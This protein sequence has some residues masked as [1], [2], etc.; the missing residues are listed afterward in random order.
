MTSINLRQPAADPVVSPAGGTAVFDA[1]ANNPAALYVASL[2]SAHSR[3]TMRGALA[4][5]LAVIG[6][7]EPGGAVDT[8]AWHKLEY[9]H[10]A[11]IRAALIERYAPASVNKMLAAVRGVL[12]SA[13]HASLMSGDA[14]ER[15][16]AAA[17]VVK[18]ETLPAGRDIP[19]LELRALVEACK[20]DG[21]AIGAR[22]A[23]ILAV[24]YAGLRRSEAAALQL[25]DVDFS[26][27][28]LTVTAGKGRKSRR[29]YLPT[30]GLPAVTAWTLV[31]GD[32]PGALFVRFTPT[33]AP[34]AA[35]ITD[36]A[37]YA[38]LH[39]RAGQAHIPPLSP[40]DF[41]R[42]MIGD[43]LSADVDI[44]TVGGLTGQA[45]PVT[46]ARYDRRPEEVR[47]AAAAK[48]VFPY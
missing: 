9:A 42:T 36:Q 26:T 4:A 43:A 13:F 22:D 27:G 47:R 32:A 8:F 19:A 23:A 10:V 18:G 3:R 29:A 16:A 28:C 21:T 14:Y 17:A 5:V 7:D 24:L 2:A 41:R 37:I 31:R 30:N 11:A 34:T 20:A 35:G 25:A 46:T 38:M 48:L 1:A 39:K 12:K 6:V 45:D 40:H 44:V 33:G 15:T